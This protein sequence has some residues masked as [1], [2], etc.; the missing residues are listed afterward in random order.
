MIV[1]EAADALAQCHAA[2]RA[3]VASLLASNVLRV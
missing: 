2:Y 3:V 1:L